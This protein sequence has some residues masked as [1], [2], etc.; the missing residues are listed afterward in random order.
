MQNMSHY[1][2]PGAMKRS[3]ETSSK[4]GCVT[5]LPLRIRSFLTL[6]DIKISVL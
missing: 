3:E 5:Y 4:R 2:D 1:W 6:S